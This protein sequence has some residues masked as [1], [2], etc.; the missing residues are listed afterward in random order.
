MTSILMLG[1]KGVER[2]AG[3]SYGTPE[4]EYRRLLNMPLAVLVL[5]A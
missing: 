2:A 1:R 5:G 4:K 3:N